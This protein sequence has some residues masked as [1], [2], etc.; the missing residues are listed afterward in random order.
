M[1]FLINN[2]VRLIILQ[3]IRS[4]ITKILRAF[5][6]KE[7]YIAKTD[8][9]AHPARYVIYIF[10]TSRVMIILY[11]CVCVMN[12]GSTTHFEISFPL[13]DTRLFG[14]VYTRRKE[15]MRAQVFIC[16][17]ISRARAYKLFIKTKKKKKR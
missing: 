2:V 3:F 17:Y 8:V 7:F 4:I 14:N 10:S 6:N 16:Y 1:D 13:E 15:Y 12:L 11:A 5:E 9:A